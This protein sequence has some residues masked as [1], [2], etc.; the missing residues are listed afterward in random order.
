[1][2]MRKQ[3]NEQDPNQRNEFGLTPFET[4]I[5]SGHVQQISLLAQDSRFDFG[6]QRASTPLQVFQERPYTKNDKKPIAAVKKTLKTIFMEQVRR[7]PREIFECIPTYIREDKEAMSFAIKQN[8]EELNFASER[9][10]E[11]LE[12]KELQAIVALDKCFSSAFKRGIRKG[13]R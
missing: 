12:L 11:D 7:E 13:P 3:M 8:P 10:Q 2:K 5:Q 6:R 9:L 4:A 1:M